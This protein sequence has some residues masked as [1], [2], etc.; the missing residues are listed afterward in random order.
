MIHSLQFRLMVAF[1]VVILV[2]TGAVFFFIN[3]A[4]QQGIRQYEQQAEQALTN[5]M[6]FELSR[7]YAMQGS[8]DGIKPYIQQWA[9]LSQRRL[10]LTDTSG[11]VIA[12]SQDSL[13]GK[14]YHPESPG[15]PV[16]LPRG[17]GV[18]T[19][20]VSS[21][22]SGLTSLLLV[23]NSVGRYLL[24][25]A[26][27]AIAIALLVTF[28]LSRRILAPIR[29]LTVTARQLGGGNLTQRV[30]TRDRGELGELAQTFNLMADDLENAEKLRRNLV[31]DAAHE[32]RT[33]LTNIKGYLEAIRDDVLKPDTATIQSIQE[34]ANLLSQLV[35]DL[36]ELALAE[37]GKLKLVIQPDDIRAV[38]SQTVNATQGQASAKGIIL[39]TE[40][41]GELPL[42]DFDWQRIRQVLHNLLDNAVAHT[43]GGGA[44]TIT[45]R[46]QANWIEVGVAD[47]GEGIPVEDLPNVFERFYRADK[48]RTRATG[49]H[50]LGLTIARRLVEAHDGKIAVD[51]EVGKGSRFTFTVPVS[52]PL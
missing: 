10:I 3:Q 27:L 47:T 4:T 39:K 9:S 21:A 15:G 25:G 49:G 22:S 19:I 11:V 18:G 1:A 2:T 6:K 13:L 14:Q 17:T 32:L 16:S 34:E 28:F 48:S 45:A 5:R 38:I 30:A 41:P 36:Q 43:P 44:I 40:L 50:G 42:C 23:Y 24:W 46:Q 31:A 8:W 52:Q 35:D 12:D 20:Y 26:L 29:A 37:A 33:P 7:Y 51:S